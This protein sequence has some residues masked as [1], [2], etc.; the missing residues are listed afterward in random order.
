MNILIVSATI[1]ES[2]DLIKLLDL[3][4]VNNN[5]YQKKNKENCIALLISGIGLSF[6]TYALSKALFENKYDLV[7]NIGIAGSFNRGLEIGDV[8]LVHSDRFADLGIKDK[9]RFIDFFEAGFIDKND[10]PFKNAE[11]YASD[12]DFVKFKN[13]KKVKAI[14][15]NTVSGNKKEIVQLQKKYNVDIESMEGAAVFYVC[16]SEKVAV[17]QIRSV[18]NYVEERDKTKWNIPLAIRQLNMFCFDL[19]P[20]IFNIQLEA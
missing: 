20:E 15:V 12:I 8:V 5:F 18:S 1:N 19:F 2:S 3:Q 9:N 7:I 6:T 17:L 14:S 4:Q 16:L 11:L 13:N 10:F